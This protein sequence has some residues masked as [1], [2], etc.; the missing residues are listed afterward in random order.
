VTV[1]NA[2]LLG[3]PAMV[4][5]TFPLD[6]P[7]GTGATMLVADHDVG[8]A[9]T[10]LNAT[11]LLPFVVPKFAPLIVTDWPTVPLAGER[12]EIVGAAGSGTR[13]MTSLEYPLT[14]PIV[15]YAWSAK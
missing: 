9:A 7:V 3:T 10:P 6:A 13:R 11:V 2:P 14:S 15:S 5:T 1:K 12:L 4:A 8:A